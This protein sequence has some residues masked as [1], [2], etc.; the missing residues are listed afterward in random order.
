MR[1]LH[2]KLNIYPLLL[3]FNTSCQNIFC[4]IKN[5]N[6]NAMSVNLEVKGNIFELWLHAAD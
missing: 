1:V 2:K 5:D 3:R 6:G 4:L